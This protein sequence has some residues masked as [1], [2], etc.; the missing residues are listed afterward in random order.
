[1]NY[2]MFGTKNLLFFKYFSTI[3]DLSYKISF[4]KEFRSYIAPSVFVVVVN[5]LNPAQDLLGRLYIF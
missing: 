5:I 3:V 4:R 2:S 1:L